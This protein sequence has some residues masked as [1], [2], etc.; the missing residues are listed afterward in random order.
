MTSAEFDQTGEVIFLI[1]TKWFF[2][3]DQFIT[4]MISNAK[5]ILKT[6]KAPEHVLKFPWDKTYFPK[7]III[8]NNTMPNLAIS[9]AIR[10]LLMELNYVTFFTMTRKIFI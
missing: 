4:D 2:L 3:K 5:H 7:K 1:D 6:Y 9:F 10:E 8:I